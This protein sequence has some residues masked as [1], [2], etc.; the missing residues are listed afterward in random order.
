MTFITVIIPTFNRSAVLATTLQRL[1]D[2]ETSTPFEIVV[3]DD[4][5][6]DDTPDTIRRF[7]GHSETPIRSLVKLHRGS[8]TARNAG[9]RAAEGYICLF[10]SD[11]TWPQRDLVERHRAFH[12]RH[13]KREAALLGRIAWAPESE[14][15]PLMK[16]LDSAGTRFPYASITES[17]SG[18]FFFASNVSVKTEFLREYGGFDEEF[19]SAALEDTELGLRLEAAGMR[20]AYDPQALVEHFHP[21]DLR[22]A[23]DQVAKVGLSYSLMNERF[24]QRSW[25][26][27]WHDPSERGVRGFL[28]NGV[29]LALNLSGIRTARVRRATWWHLCRRAF[30]QARTGSEGV[31]RLDEW[32]AW[33]AARDPAARMPVP[34]NRDEPR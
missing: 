17:L 22:G 31:R 11:D 23:L 32:L 20:L 7:A 2:Q 10:L 21:V 6:S 12:E 16:W 26:P 8:A 5:S 19:P 4:G 3:V 30:A 1:R 25:F 9:I 24:P 15:S 14:P 33:A 34:A 27:S 18:E 28:R 29:L 13:P